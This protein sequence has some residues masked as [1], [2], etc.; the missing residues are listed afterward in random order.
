MV[1]GLVGVALLSALPDRRTAC[2]NC[3]FLTLLKLNILI[4]SSYSQPILHSKATE[5]PSPVS[6]VAACQLH[7]CILVSGLK[8]V[9]Q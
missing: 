3:L 9:E 2:S 1:L 5:G 6:G 4:S 7:S 8:G